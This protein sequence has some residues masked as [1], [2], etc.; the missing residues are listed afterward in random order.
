MIEMESD[1]ITTGTISERIRR[2]IMRILEIIRECEQNDDAHGLNTQ[3]ADKTQV[4]AQDL[5]SRLESFGCVSL[6]DPVL[7]VPGDFFMIQGD[8]CRYTFDGTTIRDIW[9]DFQTITLITCDPV[10]NHPITRTTYKNVFELAPTLPSTPV[11]SRAASPPYAM[12][13]L[14]AQL[15]ALVVGIDY[16]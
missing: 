6:M 4:T 7:N 14:L 11:E 10:A 2:I 13:L 8:I 1:P 3:N 16:Q 5:W 12:E 9:E 15:N